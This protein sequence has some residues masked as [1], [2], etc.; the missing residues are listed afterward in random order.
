MKQ[1]SLFLSLLS[2]LLIGGCQADDIF[3]LSGT[4]EV[5]LIGLPVSLNNQTASVILNCA[6][7]IPGGSLQTI[8]YSEPYPEP[9]EFNLLI[10]QG[11]SALYPALNIDGI[12]SFVIGTEEMVVIVSPEKNLGSLSLTDLR[13]IFLGKIQ[14]WSTIP[15]SG[16]S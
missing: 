3:P 15:Q 11:N 9:A 7:I 10:W 1:L 16:L 5:F 12:I 8:T 2:F 14:N 13:S 6:K 4:P